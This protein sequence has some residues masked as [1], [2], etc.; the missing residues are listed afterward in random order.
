MGFSYEGGEWGCKG[1]ERVGALERIRLTIKFSDFRVEA[2]VHIP[3]RRERS[4]NLNDFDTALGNNF[5][6]DVVEFL[7]TPFVTGS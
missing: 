2:A 1:G 3:K 7:M 6:C 4:K 5:V